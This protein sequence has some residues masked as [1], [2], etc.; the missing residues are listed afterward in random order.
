MRSK[1]ACGILALTLVAACS[2]AE[3]AGTWLYGPEFSFPAG[4][5]A[6]SPAAASPAATQGSASPAASP[7]VTGQVTI[8]T[9]DGVALLFDPESASVAGDGTVDVTFE[10]RSTLPHNLTFQDPIGAATATVVDPGASETITFEAPAAGDYPFVCTL[11]PGMDG[12]LT[13]EGP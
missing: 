7:S 9:D 1:L 12:V 2:T 3:P 11:H 4:S 5:A 8:G 13:I 6:A 10:N